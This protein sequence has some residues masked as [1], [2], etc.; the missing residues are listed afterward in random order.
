MKCEQLKIKC[1]HCDF[2][3]DDQSIPK[4]HA[5][6]HKLSLV[7]IMRN[8]PPSIKEASFKNEDEFHTDLKDFLD[9]S[10]YEYLTPNRKQLIVECREC[11][12]KLKRKSLFKHL[13]N[14]H[15]SSVKNSRPESLTL[16]QKVACK[17][18]GK[19]FSTNY[20]LKRH[21]KLHALSHQT[22]LVDIM[23][24]PA[25]IHQRSLF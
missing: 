8:L 3:S 21:R 7:D 15:H 24:K 20:N 9:N 11:G 6:S 13:R 1:E 16:N 10:E 5:L 23:E 25:T 17:D 14:V 4:L 19:L 18:C 2:L 22:S 12:K